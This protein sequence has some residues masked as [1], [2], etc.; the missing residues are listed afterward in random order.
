M[1]SGAHG[2]DVSIVVPLEA[3]GDLEPLLTVC[4]LALSTGARL[5]LELRGTDNRSL[6]ADALARIPDGVALSLRCLGAGAPGGLARV[7]WGG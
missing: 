4:T 7:C 3:P 2:A 6:L 5:E 1:N